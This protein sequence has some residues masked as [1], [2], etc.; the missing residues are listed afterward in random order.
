MSENVKKIVVTTDKKNGAHGTI[1]YIYFTMVDTGE[2]KQTL[3]AKVHSDDEVDNTIA[4]V[5][6]FFPDD[7]E[8]EFI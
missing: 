7:Y 2:T 1:T 6:D 3:Y 8:F 4:E 5:M